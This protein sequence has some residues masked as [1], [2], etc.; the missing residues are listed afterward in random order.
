MD[1]YV[2]FYIVEGD[3]PIIEHCFYKEND[4]I[5]RVEQYNEHDRWGD[6]RFYHCEKI[7]VEQGFKEHF[8][9]NLENKLKFYK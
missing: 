9:F 8:D 1:V 6:G 5:S 7:M 3:Y 2:V 4:A